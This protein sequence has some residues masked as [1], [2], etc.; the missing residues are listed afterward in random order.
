MI[1]AAAGYAVSRVE[2]GWAAGV[3]ALVTAYIRA[4]GGA[5]GLPQ[6]FGGPMAKPQRMAVVTVACVVQRF[7]AQAIGLALFLIVAGSFLTALLRVR[8]L[9]RSLED[10]G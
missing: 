9:V 3:L 6:D 8:R 10:R 5:C 4:L 2:L 1:L 7:Y